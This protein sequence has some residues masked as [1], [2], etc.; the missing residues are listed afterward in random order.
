MTGRLMD[1]STQ[2]LWDRRRRNLKAIMAVK[3]LKAA[4]VS[5][6]AGLSVNAL[7]KFLRG[8]TVQMKWG[9]LEA[10]CR[11][12]GIEHP[13]ILDADNPFSD[14][15]S[16]LYRLIDE[17]DEREAQEALDQLNLTRSARSASPELADITSAK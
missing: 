17:M 15:K 12:V 1:D 6:A 11:V 2:E 16:R 3:D 10:V 8:Q 4:P 5:T 14:T 13:S 9:T 7:T